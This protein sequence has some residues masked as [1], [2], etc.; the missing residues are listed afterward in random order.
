MAFLWSSSS[1]V[2][3]PLRAL[4]APLEITPLLLGEEARLDPLDTNA[5]ERAPPEPLAPTLN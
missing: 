3:H 2:D 1:P 5:R 4:G